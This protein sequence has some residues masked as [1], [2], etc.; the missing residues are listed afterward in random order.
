VDRNFQQTLFD[1][2]DSYDF[3]SAKKLPANI[4]FGGSS[5]VYEGW[6]GRVYHSAYSS[7]ADFAHRSFQEY[8]QFPWFR[9]VGIDSGFYAPLSADKLKAMSD[10]SPDDFQWVTKACEV[11]TAPKFPNVERSGVRAGERNETFLSAEYFLRDILGPYQESKTRHRLGAVVFQFPKIPIST[12]SPREFFDKLQ[13]FLTALSAEGLRLSV[14][15]RNKEFL[16]AEYFDTLNGCGVT[17]CFNHWTDM[18][19][20]RE[21][22]IVAHNHGGLK[23]PFYIARILTPL[24][25]SYEQAVERFAPYSQ[26]KSPNQQM[27]A[28][29]ITFVKRAIERKVPA[30]IIIN[31]RCEGHSPGTINEIGKQIVSELEFS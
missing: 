10:V 29:T 22:M 5:W 21:Q 2:A 11:I 4:K 7:K 30:F 26:I 13:I 1:S 17:H 6:K 19:P 23:A 9:T 3:E 15:V 16:C 31:N 18:P 27:R 8:V 24:G 25:V 28:D 20:L 12:L 14:E